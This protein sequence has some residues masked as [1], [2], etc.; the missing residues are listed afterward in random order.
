MKSV[1][2][3]LCCVNIHSTK[4]LNAYYFL[5]SQLACMS[6]DRLGVAG[7][8]SSRVISLLFPDSRP[9]ALGFALLL[10]QLR[11][12]THRLSP[13]CRPLWLPYPQD[14]LAFTWGK[15]GLGV[16]LALGSSPH[17]VCTCPGGAQ[18]DDTP[19]LALF[20][21]TSRP[22]SLPNR[23]ALKKPHC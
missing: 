12:H 7:L 2:Q 16:S 15:P 1:L 19:E 8:G 17:S 21:L 9:P 6:P 4:L 22:Q 5:P 18:N 11:F 23:P 14:H 3:W 10:S 13:P 20:T